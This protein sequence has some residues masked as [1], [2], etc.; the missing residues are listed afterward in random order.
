[1]DLRDA[2][3]TPIDPIKLINAIVKHVATYV[4]DYPTIAADIKLMWADFDPRS[5]LFWNSDIERI[6]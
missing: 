4:G 1:M 6:D 5:G 3:T 2:I